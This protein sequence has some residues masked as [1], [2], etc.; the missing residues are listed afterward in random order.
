[1]KRSV[2]VGLPT[3]LQRSRHKSESESTSTSG[4]PTPAWPIGSPHERLESY[5][6]AFEGHPPRPSSAS[7]H[8]RHQ[9]KSY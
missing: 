4:V 3:L 6:S 8:P 9:T 2:L 7:C 5:R 1:M